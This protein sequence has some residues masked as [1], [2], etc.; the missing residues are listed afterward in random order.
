[1]LCLD[2]DACSHILK[3]LLPIIDSLDMTSALINCLGCLQRCLNGTPN[4]FFCNLL[5]TCLYV[6]N[7]QYPTSRNTQQYN[8]MFTMVPTYM[9]MDIV[10]RISHVCV[11]VAVKLCNGHKQTPS[12]IIKSQYICTDQSISQIHICQFLM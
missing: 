2:D 9:N 10:E 1:M 4:S 6:M 12:C 11:K 7:K 3:L 5:A 8:T